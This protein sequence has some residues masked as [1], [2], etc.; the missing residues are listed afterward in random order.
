MRSLEYLLT[1]ND[2]ERAKLADSLNDLDARLGKELQT[3]AALQED[4]DDKQLAQTI[5]ASTGAYRE[6]VLQAV[7]AAKAGRPEEVKKLQKT[8]WIE[9]AD[10]ASLLGRSARLGAYSTVSSDVAN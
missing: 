4:E 3:V 7:E 6:A 5:A 9:R 2:A 1:E 8:I 10:K